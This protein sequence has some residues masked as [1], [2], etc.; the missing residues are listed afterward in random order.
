M[1]HCRQVSYKECPIADKL[2][3]FDV[4]LQASYFYQNQA[5]ELLATPVL[6]RAYRHTVAEAAFYTASSPSFSLETAIQ[7]FQSRLVPQ[8]SYPGL[9]NQVGLSC[10]L[11]C[12]QCQPSSQ[13]N[14]PELLKQAGR[15]R[16]VAE[17]AM[18][19]LKACMQ[20][21]LSS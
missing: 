10:A 5:P 6:S 12:L 20:L 7:G 13:I 1:S 17:H 4:P 2:L 14:D 16:T 19:V 9:L 21:P 3:Y 8:D 18:R 11:R 15:T